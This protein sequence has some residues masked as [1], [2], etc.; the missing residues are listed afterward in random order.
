MGDHD[1]DG[2]SCRGSSLEPGEYQQSVRVGDVTRTYWLYVP[3]S[4]TGERRVPLI[5][6][7]HA[8]FFNGLQQRQLDGYAE[9]AEREGFIV[10]Y[11]DGID[12]A[13]NVG[14]CCTVSREVDDL[15]FAKALVRKLR[16]EGCIDRKR[17]YAAGYSMGG[18]MAYHLACNAANV[19]AAIAPAA[20][21]LFEEMPA[22]RP[23]RPITEISFRSTADPLIPYE[24]GVTRPPNGLDTTVTFLG[25]ERT[26]KKWAHLNRCWAGPFEKANG[27]RTYLGCRD[28]EEVTLCTTEGG[29]HVPGDAEIAWRTLK[30]HRLD[31]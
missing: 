9:L 16:H 11:P 8:M 22:C 14:P 12:N 28:H 25:A 2:S 1:S 21:D 15:G 13:W 27:C 24:G 3:S 26:F 4:Y 10:A 17:V 19:F 31:Y 23:S 5:V 18:G 6:D 29:G 30:R 7:F 20:F